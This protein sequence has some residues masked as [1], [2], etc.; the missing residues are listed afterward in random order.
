MDSGSPRYSDLR[1]TPSHPI[2]P[3]MSLHNFTD[4]H[5]HF[6][7][8]ASNA[9]SVTAQPLQPMDG[10]LPQ[11]LAEDSTFRTKRTWSQYTPAGSY[12]R[13]HSTSESDRKKLRK[14][15]HCPRDLQEASKKS[16]AQKSPSSRSQAQLHPTFESLTIMPEQL[17]Q[18]QDGSNLSQSGDTL[19]ITPP[20][21][22]FEYQPNLQRV[23]QDVQGH[24]PQGHLYLEDFD[25]YNCELAPDQ[26][27]K[28]FERAEKLSKKPVPNAPSYFTDLPWNEMADITMEELIIYFPNHV[29]NWP[30]LALLLRLTAWNQLFHRVATLINISRGSWSYD[31]NHQHAGPFPC[32]LKVQ[33]AIQEIESEYT[34]GNHDKFWAH[35][36]DRDWI[37]KNYKMKPR[38]FDERN[39][40]KVTLDEIASYVAAHPFQDKPFSQ[41]VRMV[42][43]QA[44]IPTTFYRYTFQAKNQEPEQGQIPSFDGIQDPSP[45]SPMSLILPGPDQSQVKK[46]N[47]QSN[48]NIKGQ[49]NSE[50]HCQYKWPKRDSRNI[51]KCSFPPPQAPAP[52]LSDELQKPNCLD[53]PD[54]D[55]IDCDLAHPTKDA[56]ANSITRGRC[57]P[58]PS[59]FPDRERVNQR[60]NCK[61]GPNCT[62]T[63][64]QSDHSDRSRDPVSKIPYTHGSDCKNNKHGKCPHLHPHVLKQDLSMQ[65]KARCRFGQKCLKFKDDKCNKDHDIHTKNPNTTKG[66]CKFGQKCRGLGNGHCEKD[67]SVSSSESN[68]GL[69]GTR[70]N[71]LCHFNAACRDPTCL[72]AHQSPA[73]PRGMMAEIKL[74]EICDYGLKCTNKRCAKAH[75]SPVASSISGGAERDKLSGGRGGCERGRRGDGKVRRV[76]QGRGRGRGL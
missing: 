12:T 52:P 70:W 75:P 76:G 7:C 47:V 35:K 56:L 27:K 57:S 66:K 11:D 53:D 4:L 30:C 74:E 55:E 60:A 43:K 49:R 8:G 10:L 72:R 28:E 33:K 36:I 67:H 51:T 45:P 39:A 40:R 24:I 9:L 13:C 69:G 2:A 46:G 17:R 42:G 18:Y 71:S 44:H 15:Y 38:H 21:S 61:F 41:K 23:Y 62:N 26:R 29:L 73:V 22:Q 65:G 3:R 31:R 6:E 63:N 59:P 32:M 37:Q 16:T 34:L 50:S 58:P 25:R 5:S 54:C 68:R 64:C 19:L 48:Y 1:L 20:A 14:L